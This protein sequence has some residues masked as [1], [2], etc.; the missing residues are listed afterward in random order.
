MKVNQDY[1]RSVSEL[2]EDD[3]AMYAGEVVI[4]ARRWTTQQQLEWLDT[5]PLFTERCPR[6]ERSM[7]F[8]SRSSKHW[9]CDHCGWTDS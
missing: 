8:G 5:H 3:S 7:K 9:Q 1:K 2:R 4:S 6:C